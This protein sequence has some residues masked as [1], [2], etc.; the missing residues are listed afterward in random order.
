VPRARDDVKSGGALGSPALAGAAKLVHVSAM[1]DVAELSSRPENA[2][3]RI[4]SLPVPLEVGLLLVADF[5]MMAFAAAVEPLRSA[6]RQARRELYRWRLFSHDGAPVAA[7][8]GIAVMPHAAIRDAGTPPVVIVCSGI[9]AERFADRAVFAWLRKLD[10]AGSVIGAVS[11]GAYV[12]ARAGLLDGRRC[13]L[14]WENLAAFA[15]EFPGIAVTDEI[16]AIDRDRVTCSGG[17]AALDLMLHVVRLQHGHQLATAVAEQ[18]IHG[19][20]RDHREHQRMALRARLG[21]AHPKLLAAVAA[22][23]ANLEAPLSQAALARRIDLSRRQLERLFHRYFKRTPASHYLGLRLERA[24]RILQ[25]TN[26][27]VIDVAIACG[28]VSA[29]HF[30]KCFRARFATTPR[31]LREQAR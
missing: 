16:F 3:A 18:F 6:N 23:E 31:S 2:E 24:R 9:G 21:V 28:F 10:R 4:A 8:N 27:P 19:A 17:T 25:Q 7:S 22:M 15:E 26:R 30:S 29:S 13:A 14:H 5:S 12:L 20:I 1:A 11:T